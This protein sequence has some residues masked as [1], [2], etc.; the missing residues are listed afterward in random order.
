MPRNK[1]IRLYTK[2]SGAFTASELVAREIALE[3]S[4]NSLVTKKTDNTILRFGTGGGSLTPQPYQASPTLA[5]LRDALVASGVMLPQPTYA[6][7]GVISGSV[8]AGVNLALVGSNT[9]NTT[10][11]AGGIFNFTGVVDGTY[12]LTPTISGHYFTPINRTVTVSG[13]DVTGQNFTAA[14]SSASR[15]T[16]ATHVIVPTSNSGRLR[17]VV[18]SSFTLDAATFINATAQGYTPCVEQNRIFVPNAT[19]VGTVG[20][21]DA[22]SLAY[23]GSFTAVSGQNGFRAYFSDGKMAI[24]TAGG[25][26]FGTYNF[27]TDVFTSGTLL[28]NEV[29]PLDSD[30]ANGN[31]YIASTLGGSPTRNITVVNIASETVTARQTVN[32]GS[33]NLIAVQYGAGKLLCVPS[34]GVVQRIVDATTFVQFGSDVLLSTTDPNR[35]AFSQGHWF[36]TSGGTS[37]RWINASDATTGTITGFTGGAGCVADD[38]YVYVAD[39][40]GNRIVRIDAATKTVFGTPVTGLATPAFIRS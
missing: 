36:Q 7:S 28:A 27:A 34:G 11:G 29:Y 3:E 30:A 20:V 21:W 12:T 1:F 24:V 26:R 4:S 35:M 15:T 37:V 13:A 19:G 9:Y 22:T 18:K 10:S 32:V 5:T 25:I 40:S 17:A 39:A 14:V 6:V 8:D 38:T 31:I 33:A 16:T 23:V 2:L